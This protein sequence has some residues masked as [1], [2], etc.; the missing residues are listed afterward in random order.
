V[1]PGG[2]GRKPEPEGFSPGNKPKEPQEGVEAEEGVKRLGTEQAW[3]EEDRGVVREDDM[4]KGG[5]EKAHSPVLEVRK[6]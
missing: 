2:R 3:R 4:A 6:D 5:E 1:R